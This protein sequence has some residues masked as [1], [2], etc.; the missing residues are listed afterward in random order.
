MPRGTLDI[1]ASILTVA[2]NEC[3]ENDIMAKCK[4]NN[5]QFNHYVLKMLLPS[6]LL[7]AF[8][9]GNMRHTPGYR[10][11]RRMFFQTA[12]SGY[13]FLKLYAELY[14]LANSTLW[15]K[16]L[17]SLRMKANPKKMRNI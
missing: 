10:S 9:I 14:A 4:L 2:K 17:I 11:K 7:N 16:N 13:H 1:I 3:L 6:G 5:K 15:S 8:P 12:V